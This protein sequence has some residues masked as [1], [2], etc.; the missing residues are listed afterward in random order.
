MEGMSMTTSDLNRRKE[1]YSFVEFLSLIIVVILVILIAIGLFFDIHALFYFSLAIMLGIAFFHNKYYF[2]KL[3]ELQI[4]RPT[5][6]LRPL[7]V[8][9]ISGLIAAYVLKVLNFSFLPDFR[10]TAYVANFFISILM[11]YIPLLSQSRELYSA[12][13]RGQKRKGQKIP[14]VGLIIVS[15]SIAIIIF[16]S[17]NIFV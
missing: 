12:N 15:T 13:G 5:S 6:Y 17:A 2:R 9:F 4:S 10:L 14:I 7:G 11:L 3:G 16:F 1:D 8:F